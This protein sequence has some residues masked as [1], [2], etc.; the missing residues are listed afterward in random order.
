MAVP[1]IPVAGKAVGFAKGLFKSPSARYQGG[2]LMSTVRGALAQIEAGNEAAL[3]GADSARKTAKD[4]AAWQS[5]WRDLIPGSLTSP[6]MKQLYA[7]LNGSSTGGSLPAA[8]PMNEPIGQTPEAAPTDSKSPS[9]MP[10]L[11]I[12]V[13]LV[14]LLRK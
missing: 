7:E 11:I 10:V 4:R 2:P 12:G 9:M 14:L 8:L 5:V 6:R 3:R 13:I 1:L